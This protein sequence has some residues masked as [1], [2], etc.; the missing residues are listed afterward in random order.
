MRSATWFVLSTTA[1]CS[2][3]LDGIAPIRTARIY[4]VD[5]CRAFCGAM[6][7]CVAVDY[8]ESSERICNLYDTPCSSPSGFWPS[9]SSYRLLSPVSCASTET[10]LIKSYTGRYLQ[11]KPWEWAPS[12]LSTEALE[13][14]HWKVK[15]IDI[16]L[17]T[18]EGHWGFF[19]KDHEGHLGSSAVAQEWEMWRT[20]DA[21][22]GTVF[23]SS[24]RSEFLQAT[25]W[26]KLSVSPNS[27]S[28]ERWTIT[29]LD[30]SPACAPNG[31]P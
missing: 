8:I 6:L 30:G 10:V 7:A 20:W 14:E 5:T 29:K 9:A 17:V 18:M 25:P 31:E 3:N 24:H 21:G 19:L 4:D 27:L 11:Q 28:W 12:D 23:V 26:N 13:W 22:D 1:T 15:Q 2:T 16:N